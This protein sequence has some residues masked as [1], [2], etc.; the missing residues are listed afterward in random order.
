MY[1][2]HCFGEIYIVFIYNLHC[3]YIVF[4][5]V[6]Y[7]ICHFVTHNIAASLMHYFNTYDV[8]Y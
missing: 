8:Y 6:F 3:A 1:N 4:H 5:I 2:L 7:T